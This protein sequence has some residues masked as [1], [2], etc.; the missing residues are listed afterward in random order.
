MLEEALQVRAPPAAPAPYSMCCKEECDERQS[1][2]EISIFESQPPHQRQG[3]L[4]HPQ[5]AMTKY[6]R[7][8]AGMSEDQR[9][10]PRSIEQLEDCLSH[11]EYILCFQQQPP[12]PSTSSIP[13]KNDFP[14]QSLADTVSFVQDRM[15]AMQVDLIVSRQSSRG[16]QYRMVKCHTL[17][18]YLLSIPTANTINGDN[19][20][21][22]AT[23]DA[24]V[25][26]GRKA[27]MA[28]FSSYDWNH[29]V[30]S[31]LANNNTNMDDEMLTLMALHQL[32]TF[33]LDQHKDQTTT[34]NNN[35][36]E[37]SAAAAAALSYILEYYRRNVLRHSNQ[38]GQVSP[39]TTTTPTTT[40]RVD[41]YPKFQWALHLVELAVMGRPRSILRQLWE[42]GRSSGDDGN[43]KDATFAV[44]CRSCMGPVMDM[45]R[46]QTLQQYNH[47]FGK[48]EKINTPEM[49]RLLFLESPTSAKDFCQYRAGLTIQENPDTDNNSSSKDD[50]SVVVMKVGPAVFQETKATADS[51]HRHAFVFGR[52]YPTGDPTSGGSISGSSNQQL[53]P[54]TKTAWDDDDDDDEVPTTAATSSATSTTAIWDAS[55]TDVDGIVIPPS[56]LLYRILKG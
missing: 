8:A 31:S 40:S 50:N 52:S 23:N 53:A 26:F 7:S 33:F 30:P 6:R 51:Q 19:K 9:Y 13:V 34:N 41:S 4:L 45:L 47:S 32:C 42:L 2:G 21:K 37:E 44:L 5:L 11:L 27:L 39:T 18:L 48:G 16:L 15:R 43:R 10:P 20:V 22:S 56:M 3:R 24:A 28:A 14:K 46:F 29:D 1:S 17:M 38:R 55:R 49:A 36:P 25:V 12:P 35:N 54:T